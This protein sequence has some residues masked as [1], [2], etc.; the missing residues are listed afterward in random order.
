MP[1]RQ[2]PLDRIGTGAACLCAVHCL[3]TPLAVVAFPVVAWMGEGAEFALIVLSLGISTLALVRGALLHR[4]ALPVGLLL[5]ATVALVARRWTPAEGAER[6]LVVL[7]AL[8][9]VT[10]HVVNRRW[11]RGAAPTAARTR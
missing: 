4:R 5:V 6:G 10:A 3:V 7:A 2:L 1:P 8:L 9:L 11:A